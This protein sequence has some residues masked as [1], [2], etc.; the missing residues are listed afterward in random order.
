[1]Y[2]NRDCTTVC[3]A[4][5]YGP[6]TDGRGPVVDELRANA[7]SDFGRIFQFHFFIYIQIKTISLSSWGSHGTTCIQIHIVA[8]I[9]FINFVNKTRANILFKSP[10]LYGP[11]AVSLS[12]SRN[13]RTN[14]N[15]KLFIQHTHANDGDSDDTRAKA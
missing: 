5:T 8:F 11:C 2:A 10:P 3:T 13:K 6:R 1:M 14:A 9:T 12:H 7:V 15:E 4:S